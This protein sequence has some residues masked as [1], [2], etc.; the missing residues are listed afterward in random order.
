[1]K[2][3]SVI[4]MPTAHIAGEQTG[5]L[6]RSSNALPQTGNQSEPPKKLLLLKYSYSVNSILTGNLFLTGNPINE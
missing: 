3:G 2:M 6:V 1:M 4:T 5:C